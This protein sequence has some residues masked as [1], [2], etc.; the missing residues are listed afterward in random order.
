MLPS[1]ASEPVMLPTKCVKPTRAKITTTFVNTRS[2]RL[3]G[4][5]SIEAGV[6]WVRLQ[7]NAVAYW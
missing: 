1:C 7:W 5:T 6:N 4:C 2:A 3:W